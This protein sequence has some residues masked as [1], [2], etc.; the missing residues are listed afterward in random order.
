DNIIAFSDNNPHKCRE[1][2]K[3]YAVIK[4]D[5][6]FHYEYDRIVIAM[7]HNDNKDCYIVCEAFE[8]L[9]MIGIPQNK[10]FLW[11]MKNSSANEYIG[12]D[13]LKSLY[14]TYDESTY[15]SIFEQIHPKS[16]AI[17]HRD[18]VLERC[19]NKKLFI[20]GVGCGAIRLAKYLSLMGIMVESYIDDECVGMVVD[21]KSVISSIDMVYEDIDKVFVMVANEKE[22]YGISR[23]KFT[24]MGMV[25]DLNFTYHSEIPATKEPFY[26]DVNLSYSR[27]RE[28]IEGFEIYGDFDNPKAT[29]IVA[30]GGSTTESTLLFVKGWVQFLAEIL[31]KNNIPAVVYGGGTCGYTSSQELLK[32][33]R[34]VIPLK[35]DIVISYSG[36]NDLYNIPDPTEIERHK[37]PF[38]TK[39]QVQFIKQIIE[40]LSILQYGLPVDLQ[41]GL[42]VEKNPDWNKEGKGTVFYGLQNDKPASEFWIDNM[43]MMHALSKEFDFLFL[44]FFQPFRFNGYYTSSEIQD[45]IHSRRDPSWAPGAEGGKR[46]YASIKAELHKIIEEIENYNFIHNFSDIFTEYQNIYYDTTHVYERGN[47]IIAKKIFDTLILHL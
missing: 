23:K 32:L 20:Y 35:P 13:D 2:Y 47:Q 24:N 25:E 12:F 15:K 33:I 34:D 45:I 10:I 43:R 21:G 14:I 7:P 28:E 4:P 41:Y 16:I 37:R 8:Y 44:S 27:I 9:Q 42:P 38:V 36:V 30:L 22:S 26:Y 3:G 40:K 18:Y 6:I 39:F 29:K 31:R 1:G 17:T 19:K 46:W 5:D 11:S